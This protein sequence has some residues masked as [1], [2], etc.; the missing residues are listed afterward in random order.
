MQYVT[1]DNKQ[2]LED[3]S[4]YKEE[5]IKGR[6][7]TY[8]HIAPLIS[9]WSDVYTIKQVGVSENNLPIDLITI[10]KGAKKLLMWSQ[11]H[12]NESTTTRAI[13]DLLNFLNDQTNVI[14]QQILN[15]CTLYIVPMLNPDGA[16]LYTRENHN[17]VDLNRDAQDLTQKE[18][19]IFKQLVDQINPLVAFNLHGQRTI[20]SAGETNNSAIVSFLSPASNPER[21]ITESRKKGMR[22]I[23]EMNNE[24]QKIIPNCIGRYDDGFNINCTGDT[25]ENKNITTILFEAGHHPKDYSRENT[26]KWI[27]LSL[28][29]GINYIANNNL[30]NQGFE[31]YFDI[32]ENGKCFYDIIIRNYDLEGI[33]VD[34][35]IQYKEQLKGETLSFIPYI[36][37]VQNS[38]VEFG[39]LELDATKKKIILKV[40]NNELKIDQKIHFLKINDIE[41]SVFPIKC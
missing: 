8:N 35:A 19:Q 15:E 4:K 16:K 25:L 9:Q 5:A 2:I 18:S 27:Y 22:I 3:Y 30:I 40:V 20:F 38:V 7:V 34:I 24:L 29:T 28:V 26:R 10:G 37:D 23:S 41:F 13:F 32:P 17:I 33:N 21:T 31:A 14:A 36:S 39:H 11:M 12:G 6:Y 1:M